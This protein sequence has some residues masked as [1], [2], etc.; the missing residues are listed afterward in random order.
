[1]ALV[2]D[3]YFCQWYS[4]IIDRE[5]DTFV[6]QEDEVD[7]LEWVD[8]E[9]VKQELKTNPDKYVPAMQQIIDELKI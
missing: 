7:E 6:M 2:H 8:V 9:Q 3:N 1:M 5:A 4:V